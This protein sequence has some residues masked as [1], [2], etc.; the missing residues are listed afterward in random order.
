MKYYELDTQVATIFELYDYALKERI[1]TF[2]TKKF[3]DSIKD[4]DYIFDCL[5]E[6]W[7]DAISNNK[8]EIADRCNVICQ[9]MKGMRMRKPL[10]FR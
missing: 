2:G 4:V 3:S 5:C 9:T 8:F 10:P 7:D 1:N 6:I